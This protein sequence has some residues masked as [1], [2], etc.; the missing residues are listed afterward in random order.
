MRFLQKPQEHQDVT[1]KEGVAEP[2]SKKNRKR[3]Q[4][5]VSAYFTA[6][7]LNTHQGDVQDQ[8]RRSRRTIERQAY[9]GDERREQPAK[10]VVNPPVELPEKPFLGFGSKGAQPENRDVLPTTDSYYTWSDSAPPPP[11]A[12]RRISA[13]EQATHTKSHDDLSEGP[14]RPL[15]SSTHVERLLSR[16]RTGH[17]RDRKVRDD[18]QLS[19]NDTWRQSR[20]TGGPANAEVYRPLAA[21]PRSEDNRCRSGSKT[22]SQSLPKRPTPEQRDRRL[23]H[24]EN[25]RQRRIVSYH[26]SDILNVKDATL[27]LARAQLEQHRHERSDGF[28][29]YEKENVEPISS[30]PTSKLLQQ[31]R[32]AITIPQPVRLHTYVT[33]TF[34]DDVKAVSRPSMPKE[35]DNQP[36]RANHRVA[37]ELSTQRLGSGLRERCLQSASGLA[38]RQM[39]SAAP[40]PAAYGHEM[41]PW[42]YQDRPA[43]PPD[44]VPEDDDM[45]DNEPETA[46][47]NFEAH[48]VYANARQVDEL[49]HGIRSDRT[50]GF[51]EAQAEQLHAVQP[52]APRSL[53][54]TKHL[55]TKTP[56]IR[57]LSIAREFCSERSALIADD[58]GIGTIDE[59]AGFWKPHKLY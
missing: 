8:E 45:L 9:H 48:Y 10:K 36:V 18:D 19:G 16:H 30:T 13:Q 41:T 2:A 43:P 26:T 14:R 38:Q 44:A 17:F 35:Y 11:P 42:L 7:G 56:S 27:S 23:K 12:R 20:R 3:Q 49:V 57:G 32:N 46:P 33:R 34:Q 1:T 5:E 37:Q 53:A 54:S 25:Y 59:F 22:T 51:Y 21:L 55:S 6:Q 39:S 47:L 4:E 58:T 28:Q 24:A 40:S 31:A 15:E 52:D 50:A 29:S